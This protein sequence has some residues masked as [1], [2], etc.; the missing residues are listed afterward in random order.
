MADHHFGISSISVKKYESI[1]GKAEQV[2]QQSP[3]VIWLG[4]L[5]PRVLA[6]SKEG[7]TSPVSPPSEEDQLLLHLPAHVP[8]TQ[9]AHRSRAGQ[10][11]PAVLRGEVGVGTGV[12]VVGCS[13]VMVA[14]VPVAMTTMATM[15]TARIHHEPLSLSHGKVIPVSVPLIRRPPAH[16]P[17]AS[18]PGLTAPGLRDL[19]QPFPNLC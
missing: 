1:P 2:F 11:H 14:S 18:P 12:V 13:R 9:P 7:A 6:K 4:S 10:E 17:M 15:I 8:A 19:P 16:W 3:V 5:S